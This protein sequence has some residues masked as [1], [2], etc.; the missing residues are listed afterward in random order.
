MYKYLSS[1][2][3]ADAILSYTAD[4]SKLDK[5]NLK[6]V[7]KVYNQYSQ[8]HIGVSKEYKHL[9]TIINKIVKTI[10]K[11]EL[12]VIQ[13]K[14]YK[15]DIQKV[16]LSLDEY[17]WIK[18]NTIVDIIKFFDEP[19]FTLN[20]YKKEG[21][22][23]EIIEYLL[24]SVGLKAN[25]I[26]GFTSYDSMLDSLNKG[27]VNILTT[28][29]TSLDLGD[30]SNIVK[31]KSILKT[32]FVLIGKT[33]SKNIQSLEELNGLKIA[34]VK[35]YMQDKYLNS[36][37]KI[38]K[39]YVNNND[40]GFKAIRTEK[41]HYYINNR[42][43]S[44]Y[45]LSKS[46]STDLKIVH[47][48]SYKDFPPLSISFAM[49]KQKKTLVSI[50]N[51]ALN[52]MPYKE[53]NKIK[54]KWI[55]NSKPTEKLKLTQKEQEWIKSNTVKV[56]VEQWAPIIFSTEE[57]KINGISGD[58]LKIVIKRTGLK[59][60]VINDFWDP[61]LKGLKNKTI[62]LLPATYHTKQRAEYGLYS[63]GYYKMLDY[64]YVK[65]SNKD[66]NTIEDL[67]EKSLAI[68]K[69]FGT[70]DKIKKRFPKIKIVQTM[71]LSDSIEKVL[72]GE[73]DALFDGQLAVEYRIQ[74]NLILG[75]KGISQRAFDAAKL[76]FFSR[77][78]QPILKSIL[79][80]GLN[81]I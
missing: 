20:R 79:Q 29:P 1:K 28:F 37:P 25:Y 75:L 22:V 12:L 72:K 47:E 14:V 16:S 43:N 10:P 78:D 33:S 38:Q 61:L 66:I 70:I 71:D 6:L 49:N 40:D 30:E 73:V 50:L 34:V 44:E 80:K 68:Q 81:S 53:V 64:I 56:G 32:P 19:P 63:S 27:K 9:Q 54:D 17:Q 21:Y 76:H 46:F 24:D 67:N 31:S 8:V 13:N 41:A 3:Q 59:V 77:D 48:L 36:F 74:E 11:E 15:K 35:G 62:D 18:K 4:K 5:Y 57:D 39:V 7:K 58:I 2:N 51:K 52:Q 42:A 45:I 60:K 26:D 55:L 23:Y 69:G 65:E